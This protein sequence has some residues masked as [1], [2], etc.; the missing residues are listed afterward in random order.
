MIRTSACWIRR[1]SSRGSAFSLVLANL[2]SPT[3]VSS[4][5]PELVQLLTDDNR[6]LEILAPL[7]LGEGLSQHLSPPGEGLPS[8]RMDH[9]LDHLVADLLHAGG[10]GRPGPAHQ[11]LLLGRE[12]IE[13]L[14]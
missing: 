3:P 13:L 6:L 7:R 10:R 2:T 5:L 14:G 4:T 11:A 8:D 9:F 12:P 1:S